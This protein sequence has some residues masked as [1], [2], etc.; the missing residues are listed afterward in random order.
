MSARSGSLALL[1]LCLLLAPTQAHARTQNFFTGSPLGLGLVGG[2]ENRPTNDFAAGNPTTP[3]N[4]S[5]YFGVEPFLDLGNICFRGHVSW[6]F[7]PLLS[8]SGS[9]TNGSFTESSDAGSLGYGARALMSPWIGK[10][11]RSRFYF[12]IGVN[13]AVVKVKNERKYLTG[14]QA[15]RT[16]RE[17]LQGSGVE[18]NGGIGFETFLVQN[19]SIAF[20]GGYTNRSV[21]T[22]HYRRERRQQRFP[23]LHALRA[24]NAGPQPLMVPGIFW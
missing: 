19:W 14:T 22:F 9:D 2:L 4:F 23:C 15:G 24:G 8:S 17:E 6:H 16:N 20:E 12:V 10:D 7:Y 11:A 13:D 1:F 21:K 5:S 18:L 3:S